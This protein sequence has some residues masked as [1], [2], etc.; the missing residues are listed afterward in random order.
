MKYYGL[1]G[2][3]LGHSYS[4]QI[5]N[6]IYNQFHI[7]ATYHLIEC[8]ENELIGYIQKLKDGIYSGFN[9]TIPY[10]KAIISYLDGIDEK[11]KQIG[12]VNTVYLKNGKAYG[13]NTDYDGFLETLKHY[14]IDAAK[15]D[16]FILGTGGASLAVGAVLKDFGGNCIFVSRTPKND[17]I[18]YRALKEKK[19]DIL[20]N[21]TPVG[22]YPNVDESP[23][24]KEIAQ[25]AKVVMDIIFNPKQTKLLCDANS[26]MNGLHMLISQ[27]IQAEKIWQ[28]QD[29]PI[30]IQK[31]NESI[32]FIFSLPKEILLYASNLNYKKDSLG[33]SG[34]EIYNF[35]NQY[36]LKISL[37][38]KRLRKEKEKTDW[39]YDRIHGMKS[40]AY[41][42]TQE[43]AYYLRTCLQ[44]N[45]LISK[46]LLANPPLLIKN[47]TRA[48][49]LLRS[50]DK[51]NCPFLS[52]SQ[53]N[54]FIHGDLCLPNIYVNH[55]TIGFI[56]LDNSG[57][58]DVW[59]DYAWLLWSFEFNLRTR[60][61]TPVLLESLNLKMDEKKYNQYISKESQERL[62]RRLEDIDE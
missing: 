3:K 35:S 55:E 44:G 18:S 51:E 61:W 29:L 36:I 47:V 53:G 38:K 39:L 27:A 56:D 32:E 28:N 17:E 9:V 25:R 52:D 21:T 40:I 13:T 20:V 22:M 37:D 30:S 4:C 31:M 7:D 8:Q 42:E 5:H 57:L 26:K 58:G 2:E 54:H 6:Y 45:S 46:E 60:K 19:I 41:K 48:V 14:Q 59:S 24:S 10:K 15:K 34:D 49:D 62:K 43:K 16:C 1:L 50:L 12:S 23:V 11:A 33:R